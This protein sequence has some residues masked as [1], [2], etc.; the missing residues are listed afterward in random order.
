MFMAALQDLERAIAPDRTPGADMADAHFAWLATQAEE[1]G[2]VLVAEADGAPAGFLVCL[3]ETCA[4][5]DLMLLPAERRHGVVTDI[6][7]QPE[8]RG[9]G[10]GRALLAA[11]ARHCR[12]LGLRTLRITALTANTTAIGAYR[13][14]GYEDYE[15]TLIKRL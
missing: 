9:R 2:V 10:V 4:Q 14:A 3:V 5:G 12:E 1:D 11:A 6:W 8:L 13:R 7:V 15:T